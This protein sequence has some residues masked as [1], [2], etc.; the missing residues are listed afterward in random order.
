MGIFDR[1]LAGQLLVYFGFFSLVLV[2]VYWV[3]RAL[4]LFDRLIAG[5]SNVLTFIE[6]TA[7]ALP[8]VIAVV[9]PVSALVATLYGINR[10]AAD[11]EMVVAQTTG[12]S[13]WR[14]AR[15]VLVFGLAV[16]LMVGV[17]GHI[18]VPASRTALA[19]RGAEL[20]QDITSRFLKEGE[21]LHPGTGVTVYVREITPKGELLGLFLQDRRSPAVRTSYTAERALLVR[22]DE[23]T[24][25]V[26]FDGM[27]QS[28]QTAD[29]TLVTTTFDD[30][31][32]DLAGLA[33]GGDGTR[34]RDPR[35]LST[36]ALLRADA[37]A[38]RATGDDVAKLR[39]EG[40][41]RFSEALFAFALPLLAL[42]FLMLG[43]Y[44]RLGLWRQILG[45]VVA[46]VVL[47][48]LGNVAETSAR[49]DATL[50]W[51]TYVPPLLTLALGAGLVW[52][53]TRGIGG[54]RRGAA[55]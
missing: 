18:L 43:N 41:A 54:L 31:A 44:S 11:S 29:R 24:R 36:L 21:F 15:P 45:A 19:E 22:A 34:R 26:M 1:Y 13:P 20:S 48:M 46:A 4:G 51:L 53:D 37:A 9:L 30:F 38:Q 42:G 6:F 55:A 52:H 14:L 32:Y 10:L 17:L 40:N 8:N 49:G 39:Y 7:L 28:V 25:L 3:N 12:L 47:K 33:G 27:A 5:G 50:W 16:G 2:A 35:E 23:G